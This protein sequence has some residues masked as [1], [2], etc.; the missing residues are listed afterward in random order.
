[1][2]D[3]TGSAKFK[4]YVRQLET[5]DPSHPDTWNPN[6]Q[7]LIN[8]DVYLKD[9]VEK[10]A[11]DLESLENTVGSDMQNALIAAAIQAISQAGLANREIEKTLNQRI[12]TG[13][14]TIANRGV[15]D[16]CEVTK[17]DSA[18]RNLSLSAGSI[19]LGGR[20]VPVPEQENGASVPGN[21]SDEEK[22]CYAYIWINEESLA[23]F[24][25]TDLEEDPPDGTLPLYRI[26]VPAGNTE[27]NDQYLDDCTLVDQRRV[28]PDWPQ[29]V[30]T[31]PAQYVALPYDM[32]DDKYAVDFDI[33][34]F[35]GNAFQLGYVYAGEKASN[36]FSLFLNGAVDSVQIR[37][38]ARKIGL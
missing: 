22:S 26:D 19:F 36:G 24:A 13:V 27:S 33:E 4:E 18:T 30:D 25:C 29:A 7:D 2:A 23:D 32:I 11:S 16:G 6:F 14:A 31:S 1:M 21:S 34:D 10:N 9:E 17:S 3:L 12:Q 5:T 38:T 15:V 37:W 8:N 20:R 35:D 28:E